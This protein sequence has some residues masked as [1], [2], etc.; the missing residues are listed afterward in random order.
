M[1]PLAILPSRWS[2]R[3]VWPMARSWNGR[4][5]ATPSRVQIPPTPLPATGPSPR[6]ARLAPPPIAR[7]RHR[8][9]EPPPP[10]SRPPAPLSREDARSGGRFLL[11]VAGHTVAAGAPSR[12]AGCPRAAYLARLDMGRSQ[13]LHRDVDLPAPR[14]SR[15][16][17]WRWDSNPRGRCRPTAFRV[18]R[19]RP[20]YATPPS[21]SGILPVDSTGRDAGR[22]ARR[23]AK[24]SRSSAPHSA[25]SSPP[26]RS[27]RWFSRG[28]RVRS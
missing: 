15:R 8:P 14:R 5:V 10:W 6:R 4:R 24:N 12:C 28:S 11:A 19:T 13:S 27:T 23:A 20:G 9:A 21:E 22:P 17:W 3:L 18:R 16:E 26:V 1:H 25:A 2:R 7:R